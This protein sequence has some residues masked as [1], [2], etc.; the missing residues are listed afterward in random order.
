M[1]TTRV[2]PCVG[3]AALATACAFV[4]R[5]APPA[6]IPSGILPSGS[7]EGKIPS[8]RSFG[9]SANYSCSVAPTIPSSEAPAPLPTWL[10]TSIIYNPVSALWY[11]R[12]RRRR[13]PRL[14]L[15]QPLRRPRHPCLVF[16]DRLVRILRL[17]RDL[18]LLNLAR[19]CSTHLRYTRR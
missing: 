8:A 6:M 15:G 14:A 10:M 12:P 9:P 5:C 4:D 18:L 2:P 19:R 3:V 7:S 17:A 11:P 13:P 16:L 1:P